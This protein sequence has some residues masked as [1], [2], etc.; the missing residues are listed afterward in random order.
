M[1]KYI[2]LIGILYFA[3][4][5]TIESSNIG[6]TTY[7]DSVRQSK[8]NNPVPSP[9]SQ[10]DID[11]ITA[12]AESIAKN[13][14]KMAEEQMAELDKHM[15][16]LNT[17]LS[18]FDFQ[19]EFT[20]LADL[21]LDLQD[22]GNQNGFNFNWNEKK[23]KTPTRTEKKNFSNISEIE[24]DHKYGNIVVKESSSKDVELEIQYHDSKNAK[25]SCDISTSK[26][27][28]FITTTSSSK[29]NEKINYIINIP[30]KTA[31]TTI[32]KYGNMKVNEHRGAFQ[33][34]LSYSN[35]DAHTFSE[36][37]PSINIK[38]GNLNIESAKDI[39]I[40]ASYSKAKIG[41]AEKIQLSGKYTDYFIDNV[42][43][44][45]TDDS[46]SYGNFKIG[47]IGSM[48][49]NV[50]YADINID[51]LLSDFN[52]TA[53]YG[54]MSIKIVNPKSSNITVNGSYS[55]VTVIVPENTPTSFDVKLTYG[56]LNISKKHSNVSYTVNNDEN[57]RVEKTGT[58]GGSKSP[59][60]KINVSNKYADVKI[61]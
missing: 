42:N 57:Q 56:D 20:D 21:N 38:Y 61:R 24:I 2:L 9:F 25:A 28:L 33:A 44:I 55:D 34:K 1:K 18:Q 36:T 41:K 3:I 22:L 58:I 19:Y 53:S 60:I 32:L 45:D 11:N 13:A 8:K 30:R 31:L 54:N 49:A 26:G 39:S 47:T 37:T 27:I 29:N 51:N 17:Q 7:Q 12:Q 14:G 6:V 43:V 59:K 5:P 23:E 4:L 15:A 40:V 50:K 46:H 52:V 10:K 16:E 35:L 48:K